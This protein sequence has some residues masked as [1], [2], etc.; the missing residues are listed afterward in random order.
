MKFVWRTLQMLLHT[1]A[2]FLKGV[3]PSSDQDRKKNGVERTRFVD[4]VADLTMSHLSESGHPV[5]RGPSAHNA[6]HTTAELL[7]PV[8][9]LSVTEPSR[10]VAMILLIESKLVLHQAWGTPAAKVD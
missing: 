9:Q 3:G 7:L 5:F 6:E 10:I 8:K 2:D 4:D 1:P